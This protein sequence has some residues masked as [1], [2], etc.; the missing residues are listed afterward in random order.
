MPTNNINN[1]NNCKKLCHFAFFVRYFCVFS[2]HLNP[3]TP[4]FAV[5]KN[6]RRGGAFYL[7]FSGNTFYYI[8]QPQAAF[9]I[10]FSHPDGVSRRQ[11]TL[12]FPPKKIPDCNQ[13]RALGF[14][15]RAVSSTVGSNQCHSPVI[16]CGII[17]PQN[18]VEMLTQRESASFKAPVLGA[19]V[20]LCSTVTMVCLFMHYLACVHELST[21]CVE[22]WTCSIQLP[23]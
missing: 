18:F 15:I 13:G 8:K 4:Y 2:H 16:N 10:R 1:Q 7:R 20:H 23:R 19:L 9:F 11:N 14:E 21:V 6:S 3:S 17:Q 12:A 5:T 22:L